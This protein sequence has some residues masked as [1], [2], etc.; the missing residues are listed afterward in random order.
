MR[1]AKPKIPG[2]A[3]VERGRRIREARE[4]A[5]FKKQIDLADAMG[6]RAQT[7]NRWEKR[8]DIPSR[9]GVVKLAKLLGVSP[10]WIEKGAEVATLSKRSPPPA[11]EEYLTTREGKTT[12]KD[13]ARRLK[14][15]D[16]DTLG[17]PSPTVIDVGRLRFLIEHNLRSAQEP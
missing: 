3:D 17:V 15:L 9:A 2:M 16:Y 7:V 12:P 5:G 11:V 6:V 13:I 14:T 4:R 10:E 1:R 8:G